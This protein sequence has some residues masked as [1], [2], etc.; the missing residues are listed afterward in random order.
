MLVILEGSNGSGKDYF[1]KKLCQEIESRELHNKIPLTLLNHKDHSLMPQEVR[2]ALRSR[3]TNELPSHALFF[4]FSGHL[5]LLDRASKLPGL[6][7]LER[8]LPT[9]Y[10]YQVCRYRQLG[11]MREATIVEDLID[12]YGSSKLV[13]VLFENNNRIVH[14]D[15][16]SHVMQDRLKK[17][18]DAD[19]MIGDNLFIKNWIHDYFTRFPVPGYIH[20]HSVNTEQILEVIGNIL[21]LYT[22]KEFSE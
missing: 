3:Q 1:I 6:V 10:A 9:L 13:E 22:L 16:P 19:I 2:K 4:L 15:P 11:M 5:E 8:S 12:T 17:R 20:C 18:G 14:L 21:S 7:I